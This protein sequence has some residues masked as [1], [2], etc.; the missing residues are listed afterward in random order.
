MPAEKVSN[1]V[2]LAGAQVPSD[3][4]YV[5]DVSAGAAGSKKSTLNDLFSEITKNI[6]DLSLGFG[7]GATATVSAAG[8]GKLRYNNSQ[9]R[10]EA[11][12]NGGAYAPLITNHV[13]EVNNVVLDFGAIGDGVADDTAAVQAAFDDSNTSG[14]SVYFP[15]GTYLCNPTIDGYNSIH[16]YGEGPGRSILK[17]F[18]SLSAVLTADNSTGLTHTLT[19]EEL[20]L[21]GSGSG[22]D[23]H[24]F[25]VTSDQPFDITLRNIRINDCGGAG[26]YI[27]TNA[28]TI[29][30]DGVDV[31]MP[32]T[33]SHGIDI[34]GD[35]TITLMRCYV[36]TV[37]TNQAAYRLRSGRFTMIGC[38]GIDSGATCFW[39]LFGNTLAQDGSDAYA[40]VTLIGCNVEASPT[41][42]RVKTGSQVNIFSTHFVSPTSG[43]SNIAMT[44]DNAD[45]NL[46]RSGQ[47][48]FD[49]LSG[50]ALQGTATWSNSQPVHSNGVPFLKWGSNLTQYYDTS[51]GAT[52]SLPFEGLAINGAASRG[53]WYIS[54]LAL[55]T[56]AGEGFDGNLYF[57]SDGS[58]TIGQSSSGRPDAIYCKSN[59][60]LGTGTAT[61]QGQNWV[62]TGGAN[63]LYNLNDGTVEGRLQLLTGSKIQIGTISNHDLAVLLNNTIRW[64][65]KAGGNLIVESGSLTIG[66]VT[67]NAPTDVYVSNALHAGTPGVSLGSLVFGNVLT[68]RTH[69]IT[70]PSSPTSTLEFL[71]PNADPTAGQVLTASAPAAGVV[72]LSWSAGGGG[73]TPGGS[74]TQLQYNN[75]GAFG[76]VSGITSDGTNV[77]AGSGNLR[78]TRPRFITSIDD[79]NGNEVFVITA[80]GSAVNEVTI[81]NAATGN[82]PTFT[83]SGSDANVGINFVP[84]GSGTIQV[85]GAAIVTVSATQTLT[86]KTLTTP[87]IAQISNTGTLTLPTSTDTLVG[88]ATTDTLTNKTL[89]T[90]NTVSAA[91]TWTAGVKQTFAPDA[92]TAGINV[93]SVAGDPSV[94]ANGDLWYD[95]TANELTARIN[96]ANVALGSGGGSG[97]TIGTTTI[98]S[99]TNTRVLY[100]NSGVVGE[101]TVTGTAGSVVL[102]TSPTITTPAITTS[103]TITR[104]AIGATSTDG[105]ILTNTTAAAAGAQQYS[106]RLR[107]TGQGWKTNATAASQTVDWQIENQPVQG[108]ANPTPDLVF[109][110]Q[111]NGGGFTKR[112]AMGLIAGTGN[113]AYRFGFDDTTGVDGGGAT[114]NIGLVVNN[115]RRVNL[116]SSDNSFTLGSPIQLSWTSGNTAGGLGDTIIRRNAAANLALGAADAASPVAQTLSVQNVVGGTTNTAGVDFTVAASRGTGTGNGG[117]LLFQVARPGSSGTTQ[118]TLSTVCRV[119]GST[120]TLEARA[121]TGS[122]FGRVGGTLDVD[123][124]QRA[125]TGIGETNLT[126]YTL[127]ASSLATDDQYLTWEVAGTFAANANNKRVRLYFGATVVLDTNS[128]AFADGASWRAIVS[129]F[130]T[131]AATQKAIA[132]F[133]SEDAVLAGVILQSYTTPA[134]TLSGTITIKTTGQGGASSD[135]LQEL[136]RV[137]WHPQNA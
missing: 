26:V 5:V 77:T 76:G 60:Q 79:T 96:G 114:G 12:V 62:I 100:N 39:G 45:P 84:K 92:T 102:S 88:R 128:L 41:G 89:S 17:S 69:T 72:T 40:R 30:L 119:S 13:P 113:Y 105:L 43:A 50:F 108:T 80:T 48:V 127:P 4:A 49:S 38:N 125:N 27:P 37:A 75:A 130:R 135:V 7:N 54:R 66:T 86:N 71:W 57:A 16:V 129:I 132:T 64:S 44:F 61:V 70:G 21:N 90:S 91:L 24:G 14:R 34:F 59:V 87:I 31:S 111:I 52:V 137:Q 136:H 42:I 1:L 121:G 98:T 94:P 83:A 58:Y 53:A 25:Y 116:R 107:F 10:F 33:A 85:S 123:T 134:E 29:L 74:T 19:I 32:A 51:L 97:I 67:G 99:G 56:S 36:H 47:G 35:N 8:K 81:A 106:P 18:S 104:D 78:A 126:T 3:L 2:S 118:N 101:Y 46:D 82:N 23:N 120:G 110:S 109:S 133:F 28:F 20:S 117:S 131:G 68:S 55:G 124:T 65:F 9:T 73:G 63:P 11:S 95:S 122:G 93:G 103:A 112:F 6:T 115:I 22:T 15:A